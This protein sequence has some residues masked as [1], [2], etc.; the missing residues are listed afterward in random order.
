[1]VS[2]FPDQKRTAIAEKLAD[3][4]IVQDLLISSEQQLLQE[5]SDHEITDRL[6]KMLQDD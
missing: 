6:N 4:Q 1:M 5:C 3:M 2:T